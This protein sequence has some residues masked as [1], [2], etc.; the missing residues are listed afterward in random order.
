[1]QEQKFEETSCQKLDISKPPK[2]WNGTNLKGKD[3]RETYSIFQC[4]SIST[5]N[6]TQFS[7]SFL[8]K[9]K[10][11]GPLVIF[12]CE[13]QIQ[14]YEFCPHICKQWDSKMKQT[15]VAH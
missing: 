9:S 1:M 10:M 3:A 2:Q 15:P 5:D 4:M 14:K 12:G 6:P 13:D 8:N 7:G 11:T